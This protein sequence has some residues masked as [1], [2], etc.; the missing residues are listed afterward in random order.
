MIS[1]SALRH[2]KVAILPATS[3]GFQKTGTIIKIF[4][5]GAVAL[6]RTFLSIPRPR[7]SAESKR[8]LKALYNAPA[9]LSEF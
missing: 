2:P 1:F 4:R 7:A 6:D 3:F 8:D 5:Q 9:M